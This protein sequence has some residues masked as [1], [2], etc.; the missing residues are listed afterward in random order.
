MTRI[1]NRLVW[2]LKIISLKIKFGNRISL[3]WSD[4]ISKSVIVRINGSGCI[5][6]GDNVEL[7]EG[8]ILNVSDGGRI[9][10]GNNVFMNDL[11]CLN[12]RQH[13]K[14]DDNVMMG[15]GV[16]IYDHDHDYRSDDIKGN[17]KEAPVLIGKKAWICSD[18][19]VL[20]GCNIGEN[21][22]DGASTVINKD[23]SPN[24]V[25]Y[26]KQTLAEEPIDRIEECAK[27]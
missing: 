16:K 19:I 1:C 25:C 9:S 20:R 26:R 18:V 15:Q 23:V 4:R 12:A 3:K 22:V 24:C 2:K 10:I 13:I 7:R 27:A 11:C 14:I 17:F 8:I 5:S 21:S 6:F